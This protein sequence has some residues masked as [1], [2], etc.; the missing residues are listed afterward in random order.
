MNT[1]IAVRE[2][3]D[4]EYV[5]VSESDALVETIEVMLEED[6]ETAI[7]LRGSDPV[8]VLTERSVLTAVLEEP[9]LETTTVGDAM[10][11]SVPTVAPDEPLETVADL[12]SAR[13]AG[14]LVVTNGE[15][16]LGIVTER[17]LLATRAVAPGGEPHDATEPAMSS[18]PSLSQETAPPEEAGFEDQSICEGCGTL[19][20]DLSSFNGQLLCADCRDI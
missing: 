2:V 5:G 15:K 19:T 20:R 9:T 10:D 13:S 12:L 1:D 16:P 17:D 6:A 18:D 4:R 11:A 8:G 7:V 14:R 3:M